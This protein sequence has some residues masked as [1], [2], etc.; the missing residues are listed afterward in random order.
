MFKRRSPLTLTQLTISLFWPSMG[1]RRALI[2]TKHRLL[3]VADSTHNIAFGLAIGLGVSFSPLLGTHFIQAGILA[4]LFRANAF[5]AMMGTFFGNPW[6]FPFIWW[7]ALSLGHFLFGVFGIAGT[8][9]LPPDLTIPV[10]WE[11]AMDRP[12]EI[13]LPWMLGGYIL[14][15][16]AIPPA[17]FIY[18]RLVKAAKKA[19]ARAKTLRQEKREKERLMAAQVAQAEQQSVEE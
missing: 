8:Q 19:K 9:D 18:Y 4:L 11:I 17:Y 10:L 12:L 6:T 7:G 5:S 2:Y 15:F 3:R 13:F 16:A 14:L 1:W